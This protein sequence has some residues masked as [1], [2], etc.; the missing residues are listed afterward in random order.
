MIALTGY[1]VVHYLIN[2]RLISFEDVAQGKWKFFED[3]FSSARN[4]NIIASYSGLR[5]SYFI[6]QPRTLQL[7]VDPLQTEE[8][9]YLLISRTKAKNLIPSLVFT[10]VDRKD[11]SKNRHVRYDQINHVLLVE[12]IEGSRPFL[13]YLMSCS[14]RSNMDQRLTACNQLGQ[15]LYRL[16]K[17]LS[18][19]KIAQVY[20]DPD[21]L[22]VKDIVVNNIDP[23]IL[24]LNKRELERLSDSN[25]Y[26][27]AKLGTFLL[28]ENVAAILRK[29]TGQWK[30]HSTHF[31]NSDAK[32]SNVLVKSKDEFIFIDW[33]LSGYGP[34]Q[35][36][37]AGYIADFLS[38]LAAENPV[39]SKKEIWASVNNILAGYFGSSDYSQKIKQTIRYVGLILL[40][41]FFQWA[42]SDFPAGDS[43]HQDKFLIGTACLLQP[44]E[45]WINQQI[46][47]DL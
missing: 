33:E 40:Q 13:E 36:Q 20:N 39:F 28:E 16:H 47:L 18:R 42:T 11:S 6:K 3:S 29:V 23:W 27:V 25:K 45:V 4:T 7:P 21:G 43:V 12:Y 35:W 31:I 24:Q 9:A 44:R 8:D 37:V 17:S 5:R 2:R 19:K 14:R 30:R 46:D 34:P 32:L 26:F 1:N 41:D 15:L 10:E 22:A 38:H